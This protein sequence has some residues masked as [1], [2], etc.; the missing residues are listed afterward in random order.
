MDFLHGIAKAGGMTFHKLGNGR[1]DTD[2]RLKGARAVEL[3]EQG[4]RFVVCHVNAPDEAAHMG[5]VKT[6][7][8]CLEEVDLHVVAPV[9]AYFRR[10]PERLGGL[11]VVPDHFTN[12]EAANNNGRLRGEAHSL[13]PVPFS[14]LGH[15]TDAVD[16]FSEDA[17]SRG[18]YGNGR[19]SHLDLLRLLGITKERQ[20][21]L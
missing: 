9:L 5:E 18:R 14:I 17:A 20:D 2:F 19:L 11:A 15:H 7:I 3:L 8:R 21:G 12:V 6:K 16:R 13:D 10:H 4:C 1:V